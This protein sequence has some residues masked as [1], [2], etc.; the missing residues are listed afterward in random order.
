LFLSVPPK[1]PN[2]NIVNVNP[3]NVSLEWSIVDAVGSPPVLAFILNMK[4]EYGEWQ[5]I[6]LTRDL[7]EYIVMDLPCGTLFYFYMS[8][9]NRV[10]TGDASQVRSIRTKGSRPIAPE[11]SVA[12]NSG[13]RSLTF[14]L[15]RWQ[16]GECTLQ[17]FILERLFENDDWRM[18]KYKILY[19]VF[20]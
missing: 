3:N 20:I 17:P 8:A 6:R 19:I 1:A 12:V 4:R 10:G 16:D 13:Q 9:V 2:L 15:D 5:E 18:R 7:R 11:R 14:H